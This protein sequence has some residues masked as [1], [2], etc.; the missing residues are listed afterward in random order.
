[1]V[2]VVVPRCRAILSRGLAVPHDEHAHPGLAGIVAPR[3]VA[4]DSE[5]S[6]T[7]FMHELSFNPNRTSQSLRTA[8]TISF[9]TD[10]GG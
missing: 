5:F 1:M 3:A 6:Y 7:C 8:G 4:V 2:L 10:K 9:D